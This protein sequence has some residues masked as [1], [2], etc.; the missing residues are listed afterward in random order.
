MNNSSAGKDT[1]KSQDNTMFPHE[2]WLCSKE[3]V[4]FQGKVKN[5]QPITLARN[6][7]AIQ[8]ESGD[9]NIPQRKELRTSEFSIFPKCH[10]KDFQLMG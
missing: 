1:C 4:I 5:S 3:H 6:K 10:I 2:S 9:I 7:R 8:L